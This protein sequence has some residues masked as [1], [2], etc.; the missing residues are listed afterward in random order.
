MWVRMVTKGWAKRA[1]V[2]WKRVIAPHAIRVPIRNLRELLWEET[3]A[4]GNTQ[5]RFEAWA[6]GDRRDVRFEADTRIAAEMKHG[7]VPD[8]NHLSLYEIQ[9]EA[10][11]LEK[12]YPGLA[13]SLYMGLTESLGVH[14]NMIDDSMGDF[15]PLFE[16]C[17]AAMGG[18]IQR[19]N[20]TGEEKRWRIEYLAGWSTAVFEDFMEYYEKELAWLCVDVEDLDLWRRVLEYVLEADD[21]EDR[22]CYW[23]ARKERIEESRA[24]VMKRIRE[25]SGNVTSVDGRDPGA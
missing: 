4:D 23:A 10:E 7:F 12:D 16:E 13:E 19:K 1:T 5:K 2:N 17:M 20:L 14:Y 8:Y 22:R 21:I 25:T 24:R 6:A 15:W 18:C 3:L 11:D 9:M